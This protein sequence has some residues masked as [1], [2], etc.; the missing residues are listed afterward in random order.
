MALTT[1]TTEDLYEEI[2]DLARD[3]GVSSKEQWDEMVEDVVEDHLELG[4][5]DL[6]QDTEGIKDTLKARWG[7]YK[8]ESLIS[9]EDA[10]KIE[11]DIDGDDEVKEKDDE[12]FGIDEEEDVI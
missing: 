9:D 4:E 2:S 7:A 12:G 5:L 3:Q 1:L 10:D 6:D 11:E 8:K